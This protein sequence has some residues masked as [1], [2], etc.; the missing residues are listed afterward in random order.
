M[1]RP[2]KLS[3]P[4]WEMNTRELAEATREFDGDLDWSRLRPLNA[5]EKALWER[6][7]RKRG[8]P[9][10]GEGSKVIS[11]SVEKSLLQRSDNF[12]KK[13]G[14]T[15]AQLFARALESLLRKRA[16]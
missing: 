12:A 6:A 14:L 7:K 9:P 3:K 1:K 10:V 5:K 4:Y 16:G 15:R 13:Q 8:R 2:S 11:L